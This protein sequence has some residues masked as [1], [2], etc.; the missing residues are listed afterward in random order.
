MK[1]V[2]YRG[3][4]KLHELSKEI[5]KASGTPVVITRYS[6]M[7]IRYHGEPAVVLHALG[8]EGSAI[9]IVSEKLWKELD[10]ARHDLKKML[11]IIG[12]YN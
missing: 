6:G 12:V 2:V 10:N 9:V 5:L 8:F 11:R 3:D 4:D 1:P 7:P